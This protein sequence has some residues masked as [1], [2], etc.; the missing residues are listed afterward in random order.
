MKKPAKPKGKRVV[1][2]L[3]VDRHG[4]PDQVYGP[5][6]SATAKARAA[7]AAR[8]MNDCAP[9]PDHDKFGP[10]SPLRIVYHLPAKKGARK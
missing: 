8:R 1:A 5:G 2:W 7:G 9:S 3:L 6:L 4:F 10:W